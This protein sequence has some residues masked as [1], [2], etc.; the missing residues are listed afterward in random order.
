MSG[1]IYNDHSTETIIGRRLILTTF[2]GLESVIGVQRENQVGEM[3]IT[4]PIPN[5][6]G[7]LNQKLQFEYGLIV[8]P[9]SNG[10]DIITQAE[11][12]VI[13]RWL[14]SPKLSQDLQ[15]INDSGTVTTTYCGKF[16]ATEWYPV[17][18]GFAGVKFTFENNSAYPK[19]YFKYT[20]TESASELDPDADNS[21]TVTFT[22][23]HDELDEYCY[24]ILT[25]TNPNA[26]ADITM[27]QVTD[28]N[29]SVT[30]KC[31]RG[32]PIIIDCRH[33]IL[34]DG[35]TSGVISFDRIGW[36]DAGN[37]YWP[38]LLPGSN[39]IT[40]SQPVTVKVE[41]EGVYKKV[42]GWL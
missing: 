35:T 41:Y 40:F 15:V 19:R 36:S 22:C 33:C 23:N 21:I 8:D 27:T 10:S 24:P 39:T 42:G 13:E 3:T 2:D 26:T 4:R 7:T 6:Y 28:S 34:R 38:R 14:T 9:C 37:I 30:M 12:I 1:F 32:L 11:Q 20:H 17:G 31:F 25:I 16:I 18:G 29:H 5:E